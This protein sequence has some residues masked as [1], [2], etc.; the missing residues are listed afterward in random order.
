[1]KHKL[2]ALEEVCAH[3]LVCVC[4]CVHTLVCVFMYVYACV[5]GILGIKS[6]LGMVYI[7]SSRPAK[8][9]AC[10]TQNPVI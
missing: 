6:F 3:T 1:M 7:V 8:A 10:E 4:V 9:S 2:Q 5:G